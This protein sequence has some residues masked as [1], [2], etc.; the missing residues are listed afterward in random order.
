MKLISSYN[1]F[2]LA[3]NFL[4]FWWFSACFLLLVILAFYG[5]LSL[6][7]I[8]ASKDL[9]FTIVKE[10]TAKA[11]MTAGEQGAFKKFLLQS[12]GKRF[13]GGEGD[14]KW[15]IETYT[16]AEEGESVWSWLIDWLG[17]R[18]IHFLGMPRFYTVYEYKFR[19]LSA[20]QSKDGTIEFDRPDDE[21]TNYADIRQAIIQAAVKDA[22]DKNFVPL[23]SVLTIPYRIIDPFKALFGIASSEWLRMMLN[24]LLPSFRE[25]NAMF[26]WLEIQSSRVDFS[27][28]FTEN[29]R[30]DIERLRKE[31]GL[32]IGE[33][34]MLTIEPP[35]N[36]K[37]ASQKPFVARKEAEVVGINAEAEKGRMETVYGTIE[38]YGALGQLLKYLETLKE[39]S[40]SGKLVVLSLP[41]VSEIMGSLGLPQETA[42]DLARRL[43]GKT[44]DEIKAELTK[45]LSGK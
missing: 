41:K 12:R 5:I 7:K 37:E 23:S 24:I 13:K 6:V 33:I 34:G 15:E 2:A 35:A 19:G 18:G 26:E 11:V 38:K 40:A 20:T 3:Y 28:K 22:E 9:I 8:L 21:T 27:A 29:A 25:V 36:L 31:F 1:I 14:D 45:Y 17:L 42:I 32:E 16:E 43:E 30:S 44:A 4:G 39:A 10:G